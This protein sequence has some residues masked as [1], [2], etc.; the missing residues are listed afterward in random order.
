MQSILAS[1]AVRAPPIGLIP[2]AARSALMLGYKASRSE[3]SPELGSCGNIVG[4]LGDAVPP[5]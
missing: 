2:A 1:L 4:H 3:V 5:G